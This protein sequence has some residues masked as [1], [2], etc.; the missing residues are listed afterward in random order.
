[1]WLR[2][3]GSRLDAGPD[4]HGINSV[5]SVLA[6]R[7]VRRRRF[8]REIE[9]SFRF[10]RVRTAAICLHS[11][12]KTRRSPLVPLV[13]PVCSWARQPHLR[14]QFIQTPGAETV[15]DPFANK[16]ADTPL[17]RVL[18]NFGIHHTPLPV[19][20]EQSEAHHLENNRWA[21]SPR[22]RFRFSW[23]FQEDLTF[24]PSLW[25]LGAFRPIRRRRR[26]SVIFS[27][28]SRTENAG[29]PRQT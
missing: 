8:F 27:A 2:S 14:A 10:N 5:F 12:P 24:S 13:P 28:G 16:N 6:A 9:A 29:M 4:S 23:I 20:D 7:A 25:R 17:F 11:L 15:H 19:I 21:G 26:T 1:M 3:W 22:R 18:V